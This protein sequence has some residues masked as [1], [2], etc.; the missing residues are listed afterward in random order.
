MA[1]RGGQDEAM[2][3]SCGPT[4]CASA[5]RGADNRHERSASVKPTP[6]R[7]QNVTRFPKA[8]G[9]PWSKTPYFLIMPAFI[10]FAVVLMFPAL[11]TLGLSFTKWSGV[12]LESIHFVGLRT[13]GALFTDSVFWRSLANTALFV[14]GVTV[15]LNVVGFTLALLMTTQV[16]G[17]GFLSNAAFVPILLSPA[18]VGMLWRMIVSPIGLLNTVLLKLGII[19]TA[20]VWLSNPRWATAVSVLATTWQT[21][22]F[23][24]ILY[25]AALRGLPRQLFDAAA[26]DGASPWQM[27]WHI[28]LPLMR[29]VFSVVILFNLIG[30]WST[31]EAVWMISRGAPGDSSHVLATWMFKTG[32]TMYGLIGYAS[33]VAIVI[34]VLS[35]LTAW[36]RMKVSVETIEY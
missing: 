10:F 1:C 5:G 24:L 27:I 4:P 3:S 34:A 11:V 15:L 36:V 2:T 20:V 31:F 19:D 25:Y 6:E 35:L 18:I 23:N 13:W 14:V 26:V 33:A 29:P 9:H 17:A 22:A 30:G 21:Y 32:W 16:R 8:K 12:S 28:V 7:T